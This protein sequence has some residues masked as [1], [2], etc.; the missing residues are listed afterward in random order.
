MSLP[1]RVL[2]ATTYLLTR[3]CTQRKFLFRP[4][5]RTREVVRYL[6]A[7]AAQRADV[8]LHAA[9]WLSNHVH[10]HVTDPNDHLYAPT[11]LL[12][13]QSPRTSRPA[14]EASLRA[15]STSVS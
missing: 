6:T 9:I 3:R 12:A 14:D 8:E 4:D 15:A 5:R 7:W 2:P 10:L 11:R 1:R 13:S